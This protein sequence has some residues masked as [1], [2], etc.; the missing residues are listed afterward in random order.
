MTPKTKCQAIVVVV[1]QTTNTFGI[2]MSSV[3]Q[4][5]RNEVGQKKLKWAPFSN[6]C[7]LFFSFIKYKDDYEAI[8]KISYHQ[9]E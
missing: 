5:V 7:F 9:E 1:V 4:S 8:S 6:F 2:R 3:K